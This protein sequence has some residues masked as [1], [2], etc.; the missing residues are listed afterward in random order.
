MR[1]RASEFS[2]NERDTATLI[3]ETCQNF[4]DCILISVDEYLVASML[5]D[6]GVVEYHPKK[7]GRVRYPTNA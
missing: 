6:L 3:L 2:E 1:K 4:G 7:P 5:A